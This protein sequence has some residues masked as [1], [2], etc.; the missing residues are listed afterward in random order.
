M[1]FEQRLEKAIQRGRDR[2]KSRELE[3]QREALSAE[4]LKRMHTKY[5]LQLSE[6]I[7]QCVQSLPQHFP[8]FSF[9]TIYGEK[10]W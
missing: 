4:E 7:E 3:A 6:H 5:R 8:G 2:Q 9:E 10:G 1:E